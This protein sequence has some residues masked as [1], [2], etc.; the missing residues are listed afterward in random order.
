[1]G[2]FLMAQG[3]GGVGAAGCAVV[4]VCG[5]NGSLRNRGVVASCRR[6]FGRIHPSR[7]QLQPAQQITKPADGWLGDLAPSL[8]Y[9][10]FTLDIT[11]LSEPLHLFFGPRLLCPLMIG[12]SH[13][14]GCMG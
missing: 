1:M 7:C 3:G 5:G 4:F 13:E 10:S 11:R 6:R 9:I 2:H 14:T 8:V 12:E